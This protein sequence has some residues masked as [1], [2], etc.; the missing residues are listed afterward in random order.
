MGQLLERLDSVTWGTAT[1]HHDITGDVMRLILRNGLEDV[2][3][4]AH[5]FK[6]FGDPCPGD[7]KILTV[8]ISGRRYEFSEI[9]YWTTYKSL[10]LR[11]YFTD[12][13]CGA[14]QTPLRPRSRSP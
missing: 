12:A 4:G 3:C 2:T 10:D 14:D 8:T 11:P 1:L 6:V 9:E 5:F 13:A 7:W